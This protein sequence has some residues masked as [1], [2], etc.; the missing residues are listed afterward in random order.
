[1][2]CGPCGG[3]AVVAGESAE[4]LL[5]QTPGGSGS[6][7]AA[8]AD[9]PIQMTGGSLSRLGGMGRR[10]FALRGRWGLGAWPWRR[11]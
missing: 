5:D 3:K 1:M 6:P 2:A 9:A 8:T 4:P 7:A 10:G 11:L